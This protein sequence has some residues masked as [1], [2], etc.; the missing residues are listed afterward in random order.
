M[1]FAFHMCRICVCGSPGRPPQGLI[2]VSVNRVVSAC[3]RGTSMVCGRCLIRKHGHSCRP[4]AR[5]TTSGSTTPVPEIEAPAHVL[6]VLLPARRAA[7]EGS[8]WLLFRLVVCVFGVLNLQF[9]FLC[10]DTGLFLEVL[11]YEVNPWK[12][13]GRPQPPFRLTKI[14]IISL[15]SVGLRSRD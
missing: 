2:L 13:R 15:Q 14:G 10:F 7:K 8:C 12:G 11:Q 1:V 9:R 4:G 5:N 3:L 6:L